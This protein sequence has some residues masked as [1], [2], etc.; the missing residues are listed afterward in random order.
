[1]TNQYSTAI[2]IL[3]LLKLFGYITIIGSLIGGAVFL[4]DGDIEIGLVVA[5]SGIAGGIIQVGFAEI[6]KA[7]IDGSVA[8]QTSA[9]VLR[10]WA[11]KEAA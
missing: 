11:K 6:G 3:L 5:I 7:L 1:M 2:L 8:S 10:Q 4:I 9:S